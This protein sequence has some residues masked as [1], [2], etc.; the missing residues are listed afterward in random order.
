ML[1][2]NEALILQ[3]IF[4]DGDLRRSLQKHGASSLNFQMEKLMTKSARWIH[5]HNLAWDA[6]KEMEGDQKN[7]ITLLPVLEK[8]Q[9]VVGVI[10][11]HD[12]VQSGL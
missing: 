5:A 7:A 10:K 4:T 2:V 1:I 9:K 6:M 8:D 11:L 12:I 3:G